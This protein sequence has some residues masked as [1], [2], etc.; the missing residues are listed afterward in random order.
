MNVLIACEESGRVRDA[1]IERGH[2]AWSC[3]LQEGRGKHADK[4]Y[5]QD[6]IDLLTIRKPWEVFTWDLVIA[7]PPCTYI[8]NSGVSWLHKDPDRWALLDDACDFFRF[9]LELPYP[10]VIENPI[11]HKYAVERI[12]RK[13]DQI[14]HPYQ[15]G[16]PE[17]KSTCLWLKDVPKLKETNNVKEYMMSL[18]KNERQ[19]LHYL[20]PSPDR[21]K[22]RSETF[23]GIADAMADQWSNL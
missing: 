9:F 7:H 11:P 8:T 1:F 12:G 10:V 20:P 16:H 23:Q 14:I 3:D 4:H 15:F 17:Q 6:V 19:R 21:A 5:Q 2:N 18:P 22:L 13:Y